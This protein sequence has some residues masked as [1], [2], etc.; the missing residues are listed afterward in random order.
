MNVFVHTSVMQKELVD[1]LDLKPGG[2]AIDCTSGAGGHTKLLLD[3]VKENGRI[4]ALDRDP[5]AISFLTSSLK[6]KYSNLEIIMAPFSKIKAI[7]EEFG[8]TKCI[9]GIC[10]DIGVSSPQLDNPERGFSFEKDGP[11]D[12][13]MDPQ[14]NEMTAYKVINEYSE[15]ELTRIFKEFGEEPKSR[16]AARKIVAERKKSPINSTFRLS[17]IIKESIYYKTGSKKHP[18]TKIF[19]AIRIYVNQE[20]NELE[21]LIKDGFEIL[22]PGGRLAIISFHS[23]EDRIIKNTFNKLGGKNSSLQLLRH[24]PLTHEEEMKHNQVQG[25][26]IKPFPMLPSEDEIKANPRSR[27]AKL[28]IIEKTR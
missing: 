11:L 15:D 21:K 19:Q 6:E 27:S 7:A 17:E 13:R 12:M 10:A 5:A 16:F 4:F 3:K 28:R 18:A 9:D 25:K 1:A 22:S 24:V 26:I 20:L 8:I 23:L 14:N 2:L